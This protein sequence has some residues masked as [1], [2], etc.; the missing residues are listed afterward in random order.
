MSWTVNFL[1]IA[2]VLMF[3]AFIQFV[4]T[5]GVRLLTWS[6]KQLTTFAKAHDLDADVV[7]RLKNNERILRRVPLR[8]IELGSLFKMAAAV[9]ILITLL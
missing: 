5:F 8:Q 3:F 7:K 6:T 9:I 2:I 4:F 1:A